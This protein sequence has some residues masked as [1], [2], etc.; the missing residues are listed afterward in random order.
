MAGKLFRGGGGFLSEREAFQASGRLFKR[1]GG[2]LSEPTDSGQLS[3]V[4]NVANSQDVEIH[5][6]QSY[7]TVTLCT[8]NHPRPPPDPV[9]QRDIG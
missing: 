9:F 1:A 8:C 4:Q 5:I 7:F 3:G 2:F 6:I